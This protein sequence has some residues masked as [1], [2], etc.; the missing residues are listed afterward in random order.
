MQVTIWGARGSIPSPGHHTVRHGGNTPCLAVTDDE[1]GLLILDGGTGIRA[2]GTSLQRTE[3]A[4]RVDV[5]ITHAHWDHVQ[6]LPFFAPLYHTGN[7]VRIFGAGQAANGVRRAIR[8][9]MDQGTFP[10]RFEDLTARITLGDVPAQADVGGFTVEHMPASHQD[11]A[12]GFRVR[13]RNGSGA[14]LVYLPDNELGA[15]QAHGLDGGWRARLMSFIEGAALLVHDAMYTEAEY[16]S[17]VGWGHSHMLE[18]VRVAEEAGVRTLALFHHHPDRSDDALDECLE[19]CRRR[20]T[21][22]GGLQV[23]MA[24]EGDSLT[25]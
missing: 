1:G 10:V 18:V 7:E 11:G 21:P 15:P 14:A 12:V 9:Q 5:L 2:L 16:A 6:G 19:Q 23:R 4:R 22:G 17:Y 24:A 13:A 8:G 25:V 20:A 3:S